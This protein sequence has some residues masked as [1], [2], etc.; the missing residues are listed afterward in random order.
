MLRNEVFTAPKRARYRIELQD[1]PGMG[2][3]GVRDG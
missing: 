1:R 3:R 2:Q